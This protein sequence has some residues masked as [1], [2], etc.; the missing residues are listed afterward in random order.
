MIKGQKA[1][2][3]LLKKITIRKHWCYIPKIKLL[4]IEFGIQDSKE[5]PM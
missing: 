3:K 2:E 4:K 5:K 1:A